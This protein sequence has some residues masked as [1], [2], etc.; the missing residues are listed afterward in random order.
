MKTVIVASTV[1]LL[2][3]A[4]SA[5]SA[6]CVGL[7]KA[8]DQAKKSVPWNIFASIQLLFGATPPDDCGSLATVLS[9]VSTRNIVG[10]RRLE[11]QRPLDE[12]AAK[13]ELD[14][15]LQDDAVRARIDKS[16]ADLTDENARLL[17]EAVILDSEGYYA[18][19]DLIVLRLA[20]KSE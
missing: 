8:M 3:C 1:V 2:L 5:Q 18:A 14:K 12:A 19:R 20:Q 13:T 10:G 9:R 17:S 15:A 6:D 16:R 4:A 7:E 11:E